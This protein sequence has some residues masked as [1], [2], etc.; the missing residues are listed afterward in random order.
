MAKLGPFGLVNRATVVPGRGASTIRYKPVMDS[1]WDVFRDL[2]ALFRS[3]I[4]AG[5][6]NNKDEPH[7]LFEGLNTEAKANMVPIGVHP[8]HTLVRMNVRATW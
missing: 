8:I 2:Y 6:L 3:L 7:L 5:I 1:L 4:L